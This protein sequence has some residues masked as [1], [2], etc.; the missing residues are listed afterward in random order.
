VRD[1]N[2]AVVF[3]THSMRLHKASNS[4]FVMRC[5]NLQQLATAWTLLLPTGQE[6]PVLFVLLLTCPP[7][8]HACRLAIRRWS[9]LPGH[10]LP[11]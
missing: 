4:Y 6:L 5:M 8:W 2:W 11:A 9:F 7:A 1:L 3:L 10:S